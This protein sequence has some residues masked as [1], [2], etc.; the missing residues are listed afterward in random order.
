MKRFILTLCLIA[1]ACNAQV[2]PQVFHV[3]TIGFTTD[4]AT[5][6][7]QTGTKGY[8]TASFTGRI[9]G[10]SITATGTNPTCTIDVWKIGAGTALPTVAN[11]ITAAAK[12]ALSTGN[13][14]RSSNLT[15]WTVAFAAGDIF[16]FNVDAVTAATKITFELETTK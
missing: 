3:P 1:S 11:T 5:L 15:G 2:T 14:K 13:A 10:W 16:G 9:T 12:P 4:G 7:I 6:V 8:F